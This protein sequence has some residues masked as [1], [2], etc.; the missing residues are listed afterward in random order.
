[1]FL[2]KSI[3]L[4][5][6]ATTQVDSEVVKTISKYLTKKY[7]NPSSLHGFGEEAKEALESARVTVAD[8]LKASPKEIIFTSGGTESDNLAIKGIAYQHKTGH[9]I[10]SNVEHP[11]VLATCRQLKKE[12]Y[13]LTILK[14]DSLGFIN[15]DELKQ[16]IRKERP[17]VN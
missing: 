5:N 7:G 2:V 3:Y 11:A 14:V 9:I 12:G 8:S 4:D 16:A 15:L 13:D 10:T 6:G 1:M 17:I